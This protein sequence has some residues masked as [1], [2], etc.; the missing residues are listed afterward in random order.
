MHRLNKDIGNYGEDIAEKYLIKNNYIIR[1]RNFRCRIGEIDI[2]ACD[3]EY[4]CFIEVKTRYDCNFGF[5]SEAVNK[6]KQYK[7]KKLAEFYV[8]KNNY[9]NSNL[10]FDTVEII[11]NSLNNDHEINLIKNAFIT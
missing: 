8:Y 5:P 10:R 4:I 2:V 11:L 1:E 3:E 9:Y 7:L 6:R